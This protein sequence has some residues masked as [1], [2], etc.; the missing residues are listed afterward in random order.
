MHKQ[1]YDTTLKVIRE[2]IE[3]EAEDQVPFHLN[4]LEVGLDGLVC[5]RCDTGCLGWDWWDSGCLR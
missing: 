1:A 2:A 5:L 3:D 4:V